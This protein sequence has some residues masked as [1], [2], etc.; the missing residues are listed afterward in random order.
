M[1]AYDG[2]GNTSAKST[3]V[4]ATTAAIAPSIGSFSAVSA[5][6]TAGQSTTLTWSVSGTPDPAVS[7]DSGIGGVTGTSIS[8]TPSTTT[9][10]TLT[11]TNIGESATAQ[12]TVT[13]TP[14]PAPPS[15][16]VNVAATAVSASEIDI[17]W[18]ASTP[19]DSGTVAGY[20]VYRNGSQIA[21]TTVP[22][23]IDIGLGA[24]T[25]YSYAVAAFDELGNTS[26]LS[27][28]ASA[29][30]FPAPVSPSVNSFGASPATIFVGQ[31][32]SLMW[33]VSGYPAPDVSI[34]NGVGAVTGTS[35][36]VAPTQTTIYTIT[37]TNA[38]G[39]TTAQATVLVSVPVIP[40]SV[41]ANVVAAAVSATE[42]DIS[43]DAATPGNGG[44]ITGYRIYRN[45]SQIG[46]TAATSYPDSGLGAYTTYSYTIV[47][48]DA[49]GNVSS[50]STA[51]A[52][53]TNAIAPSINSFSATPASITVG[54]STTLAWSVAGA[55]APGLSIDNGVGA[56]SGLSVSVAPSQT[57]TYTLTASNNAGTVTAQTTVTVT[58][59]PPSIP[60]GLHAAAISSSEIDLSWNAS[61]PG[62]TGSVAGYKICRNGVQ[63]GTTVGTT[64]PD[65]GLSASTA[66]SYTVAAFD[67][68]GVTSAKSPAVQATTNAPPAAP[69]VNSFSAAPASV[70]AGQSSTLAWSV[71]GNPA[72]TVSIDN[73]VGA[74]AGNSVSV[75]PALTTTYTLTATNS[76]G[77][78]TAQTTVTVVPVPPSAPAGLTTYIVSATEIDLSW[79][80][81]TPGS[82]GPVAGY[83][84][85]RNGSQV[86]ATATTSYPDA[87]LNANTH[88]SYAVAA[89]DGAGATSA[90][91]SVVSATTNA[92][93]QPPSVD[94]FSATPASITAG[95]SST[96]AWSVSG[97]PTPTI[98]ISGIGTVT[99]T[100]TSVSPTQTT[101]YNLTATSSAGTAGSQVTVT[102]TPTPPSIPTGLGATVASSSEIDLAWTAS[103][104]GSGG[105]VAGYKIFRNGSQVGTSTLPSYAD[106]G[107]SP[108]TGYSYTVAAFD[109]VGTTSAPTSAVSAT[110]NPANVAPA[111]NSF[112]ATPISITSGQSSTLAWS[113]TGTPAPTISISNGVGTVTG[114]S[115]SVSPAQTT[116]YALTA[117]S[118]AGTAGAQV[119]VTVVATGT[120]PTVPAG[121]KAN[122]FSSSEIDL[123]WNA[124][125]PGTGGAVAGYKIYRNG[126]QVGT[127]T[128]ISYADFGL[129]PSTSYSYA[130]SAFD[131]AGDT[132]A[133]ST[134]VPATT[135]PDPNTVPVDAL[136]AMNTGTPGTM[137]TTATMIAGTI[138]TNQWQTGNAPVNSMTIAPSMNQ[139]FVPVAVNGVSYPTTYP[140]QAIA[141]DD[142]KTVQTF[143]DNIPS[144]H[145]Q[146]TVAGFVT[147]GPTPAPN[148]S[149]L[150]DYWLVGGVNGQYAVMQL[151]DQGTGPGSTYA[152]NIETRPAN[153]TIHSPYIPVT[154]GATYWCVL[155]ADYTSGVAQLIIYTVPALTQVG[156]VTMTQGTGT[157]IKEISVGNNEAGVIAG[158]QS[159]FENI[160]IDYTNAAF[161]LGLPGAAHDVTPPS[162]PTGLTATPVSSTDISLAWTASTDDVGVLGYSIFRNGVKVGTSI[163]PSYRDTGLTPSTMYSYSVSAYDP[164]G[165]ASTPSLSV[166][167]TTQPIPPIKLVQHGGIDCGTA[168]T[169]ALPFTSST[170]PGDLI[171][172]GLR[173]WHGAAP[174][175]LSDSSGNTYA[176]AV[177]QFN[178]NDSHQLYL[179]YAQNIAGGPDTVTVTTGGTSPT[180]RMTALEYSGAATSGVLDR[181]ASATGKGTAVSSGNVTTLF[182]IELLVGI[183]TDANGATWTAGSTW[184]LRDAPGNRMADEDQVIFSA[185]TSAATFTTNTSD[186][187]TAIVATFKPQ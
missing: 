170:T 155:H 17:S 165:N 60:S 96:L 151:L 140:S 80:A 26:D 161:P 175:S 10:Y 49:S 24:N 133:L 118:V 97:S 127:S 93:S 56:V 168:N 12:T 6:I 153:T 146:V 157:D 53:T 110:T 59:T 126:S 111:V 77:A 122:P 145:R 164:T 57:T 141:Y 82:G 134:V 123:S 3:P 73:G 37:A 21:A 150:F 54:Q 101:I 43:W 36:S 138:G 125:T 115:V 88:Y 147:L 142:T 1:A 2:T 159:I 149:K 109:G 5:T 131:G 186:Y 128:L 30:T 87:G 148:D 100:S 173:V 83:K 15:V 160:I 139:R 48:V 44:A 25:S 58:A 32:T 9:T 52:A 4:T 107:L 99:G 34:D 116:T 169:C 113:V 177:T 28:A 144:G 76:S 132:S 38:S 184:S 179:Y 137:I 13:V 11:A 14:P 84:I 183:A 79:T 67:G 94:S 182:P 187:W 19:G 171:V 50:A 27:A 16:P 86:G 180:I 91:S 104:P 154:P 119:I 66:Y 89:F 62:S 70:N 63:I 7:I 185:G 61:S 20:K 46:S 158:T 72:P 45:N 102:V 166:N 172:I 90:Q 108:S 81:S 92:P 112:T 105:A 51:V 163:T 120:A 106:T 114:T 47:A 55:P 135:K 103:T 78:I 8:V 117:T 65:T 22:S 162:T 136:I 152:F 130:V 29:K 143:Q 121:L 178:S 167:A 42:I 75:T 124:S 95:Q 85:Y 41:P 181:V 18:D 39:T 33:S 23:Y 31:P 156:Y 40:P 129:T 74:V 69:T 176:L 71:S 35:V 98:S 68:T 64:Y 174:L